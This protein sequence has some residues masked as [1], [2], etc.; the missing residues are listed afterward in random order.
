M[1]NI[2]C[3]LLFCLFGCTQ[4]QFF[5]FDYVARRGTN[6]TGY[7]PT[8]DQVYQ[9]LAQM[10]LYGNTVRLYNLYDCQGG[11]KVA[12]AAKMLGMDLFLGMQNAPSETLGW[13]KSILLDIITDFGKDNIIGVS[14]GCESLWRKD[15][16]ANQV[17]NAIWE[18]KNFTVEHGWT[19][20]YGIGYADN[21]ELDATKTNYS[22]VR[23]AADTLIFNLFSY[24]GGSYP[25]SRTDTAPAMSIINQIKNYKSKYPNKRVILGES[26]WPTNSS[27]ST[28]PID[29]LLLQQ[30]T[31]ET[32]V[33]GAYDNNVTF[34]WFQSHDLP[35]HYPNNPTNAERSWGLWTDDR[36]FKHNNWSFSCAGHPYVPVYPTTTPT[37]TTKAPVPT[38]KAPVVTTK[39]PTQAPV[40]KAPVTKAPVVVTTSSPVVQTSVE[41]QL[42]TQVQV[43]TN[44]QVVEESASTS[45]EDASVILV[46]T[47]EVDS[48]TGNQKNQIGSAL[49]SVPAVSLVLALLSLFL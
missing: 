16:P 8:T 41:T 35:W 13:E 26:G 7:C 3:V 34:F 38:T 11:Y 4:A 24:Y 37:P 1:K 9:D 28:Y 18:V 42:N 44:T 36:K 32:L 22:M 46:P 49:I 25:K 27:R 6:S 43:D 19:F 17:A 23:D 48:G 21:G 29:G 15:L 2:V 31:A 12:R 39:A 47:L 5:G 10:K 40:T 33:C 45:P 20:P 30:Y 14:V